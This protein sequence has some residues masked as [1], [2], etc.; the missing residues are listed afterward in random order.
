MNRTELIR[1]GVLLEISD[2]YE[3]PAHVHQNL[4]ERL[5]VCGLAVTSEDIRMS[6]IDL[7]QSGLATAYWLGTDSDEEV[8]GLP[9]LD[10]F[11]DFFFRITDEGNRVLEIWRKEWPLD[12]E[13]ELLP[14]W[15]PPA[16]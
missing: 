9:P 8:Q 11:Q 1:L 14:G 3:E 13:D 7:I 10:R 6:L 5:K 4:V 15:S 2:D 12:E 16:G